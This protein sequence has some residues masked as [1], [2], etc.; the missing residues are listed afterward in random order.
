MHVRRLYLYNYFRRLS[1]QILEIDEVTT[2]TPLSMGTSHIIESTTALMSILLAP[3]KFQIDGVQF[4][5]YCYIREEKISK[6][7]IQ[8]GLEVGVCLAVSALVW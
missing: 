1:Q 7:K 6:T 8:A 2:N 5:L 3:L 4:L